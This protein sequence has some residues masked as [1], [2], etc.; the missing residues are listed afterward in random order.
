MAA[1]VHNIGREGRVLVVDDFMD[2]PERLIAEAVGMAPF[3]PE[4]AFFYPGLRRL[5]TPEDSETD[6]HIRQS[7]QA[8]APLLDQVFGFKS[9]R[10]TEATFC[11]VTKRPEDLHPLQSVPHFDKTDSKVFALLHFLSP[12]AQGGTS[13][14][15]H[16]RTGF[17]RIN[18]MRLPI[19]NLARDAEMAA[20]VAPGM[21]YIGDSTEHFERIAHFEGKY[22]RL[23]I[24]Q[25]CLLH[26]GEIPL[27]FNFSAD[28]A[29]GRLTCNIFIEAIV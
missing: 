26:S 9:L 10:P 27:D 6:A 29:V 14:Y 4:Q 25:G 19:Y 8:L 13:F 11:L 7:L 22:N 20:E 3:S 21:G 17:E 18:D 15:R 16:R 28:P 12:V 1:T 23:L 2:E 24:Y 5:L